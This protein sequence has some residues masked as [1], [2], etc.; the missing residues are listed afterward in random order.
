[1]TMSKQSFWA[2]KLFIAVL[3]AICALSA[4]GCGS[5]TGSEKS[6][7]TVVFTDALHREIRIT[8]QPER[9]AALIGGFAD[10]WM[11][12][13]GSLCAA[14]ED[15]WTDYELTL[16]DAVN[17]GGAHS[18]NLE[19]LLAAEP[20]FVIASASNKSNV[21]WK[22]LLENAGIAVAYFDV[23]CFEQ[24]LAMLDICTD[25]TGRKD[26][27]EQNGT[28]IRDQIEVVKEEVAEASLS[29]AERTVL[30]LRAA[31]GFVKTKGSSGTVLGEMLRELGCINIADSDATLMEALNIESILQS[32]PHRIFVVTM[33]DDSEKALANLLALIKDDPAWGS[34]SAIR[35]NRLH[36]MDRN[37]YHIK[38][39]EKWAQSYERLSE[40]LLEKNK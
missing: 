24:Y 10:V 32:D 21:A 1:M 11:L 31:T 4:G 5:S 14:P 6:E 26:L 7:G 30:L 3:S 17:L 37:L 13:G 25:I 33:G 40:I 16:D 34:L 2:N 29:E 35:E 20:D 22:E 36:I 18:A 8:K 19:V 28:R 38:P 39:N 23:D 12:A 15:A 27:Y 9:V